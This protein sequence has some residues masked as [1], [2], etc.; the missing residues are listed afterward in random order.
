MCAWKTE[1]KKRN[2]TGSETER[3][4][5]SGCERPIAW[6]AFSLTK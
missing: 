1:E 4:K 5:M 2:M 6:G 3:V